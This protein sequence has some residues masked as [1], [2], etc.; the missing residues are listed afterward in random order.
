M[1]ILIVVEHTA[2]GYSAFSP[3]VPGCVAT[4]ATRDEVEAAM[5]DAVT[6]H[7]EGRRLEGRDVPQP[8]T[9]A[10]VVDVAA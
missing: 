10:T 1:K 8:T 6:F 4:G 5:R 3:D 7:I 9:Y 2:T